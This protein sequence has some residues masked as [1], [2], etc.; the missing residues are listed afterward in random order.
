[1]ETK[2]QMIE[3]LAA[4]LHEAW[5]LKKINENGWHIPEDCPE[6]KKERYCFNCEKYNGRSNEC[7]KEIF[8]GTD[9][10]NH[11]YKECV[12]CHSCVNAW[13][14]ITDKEKELALQNATIAYNE[15]IENKQ[16]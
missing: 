15:L 16:N 4:K 3:L 1:M 10:E 11:Q 13:N 2:E 9:C 6:K 14:K 8:A 12:N 5:R 7:F